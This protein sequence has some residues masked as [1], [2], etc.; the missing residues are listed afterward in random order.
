[1]ETIQRRPRLSAPSR[2]YATLEN[3]SER[4]LL[5]A[6]QRRHN[7]GVQLIIRRQIHT[8]ISGVSNGCE[9]RAA[10]KAKRV[11]HTTAPGVYVCLLRSMLH[12]VDESK[13]RT[14]DMQKFR[15]PSK[16]DSRRK[17]VILRSR[18]SEIPFL[19]NALRRGEICISVKRNELSPQP[20]YSSNSIYR[21]SYPFTFSHLFTNFRNII[22]Q[23]S[24]ISNYLSLISDPPLFPTRDPNSSPKRENSPIS[25]VNGVS[26][27]ESVSTPVIETRLVK[28]DTYLSC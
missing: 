16:W 1:M 14:R 25:P 6:Y 18:R 5:A 22:A 8:G 4:R 26:I 2:K 21:N 27:R 28:T 20:N 11:A 17:Y 23:F 10:V 15:N 9:I 7:S 12:P 3:A 24:P 19:R 13:A